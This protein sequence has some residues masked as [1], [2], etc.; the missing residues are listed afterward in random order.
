[1]RSGVSLFLNLIPKTCYTLG[2]SSPSISVGKDPGRFDPILPLTYKE[3][4]LEVSSRSSNV[5][6]LGPHGVRTEGMNLRSFSDCQGPC[7]LVESEYPG[8]LTPK[9]PSLELYG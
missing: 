2:I 5:E 3:F 6:G 8:F 4:R 7:S 1:M 9:Q